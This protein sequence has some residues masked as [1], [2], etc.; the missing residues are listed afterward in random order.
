MAEAGSVLV[1]G[2][3]LVDVIV[4]DGVDGVAGEHPGGSPANVAFGLAR[5]GSQV[6]LL[7]DL[8]D[9]EYGRLVREHLVQAGVVLVSQNR[10][11]GVTSSA[12]AVLASD[13]SA[14][15]EFKLAWDVDVSLAPL[16]PTVHTGSLGAVLGDERVLQ[17]IA[18]R[19]S[20]SVISYDP[21]IR[22]DAMGPRGELLVR[23]ERLVGLSDLVK[24]SDEDLAWLYP[25]VSAQNA[26]Q[27]WAQLGPRAVIV[28]CGADGVRA[29][30]PDA[31]LRVAAFEATV[32]DTVGAGDS[33][34]AALLHSLLG[35]GVR[36]AD[37]LRLG[38]DGWRAALAFAAAAA[39][40]TV[41][42]SG[43]DLPWLAEVEAKLA[44]K[45]G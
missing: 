42:R 35:A 7:T 20:E 6:A 23:V 15:Y 28:T 27:A 40:V 19:R 3:A 12:T 33:F 10:P 30:T 37:D 25:A 43:A 18:A 38:A 41:T 11:G 2:E 8:G 13:G 34:M 9:D 5:L 1:V 31:N 39:A 22:P 45:G 24:V 36:C 4:G 32:L 44:C 16:A 17:L 21:N 26:A 14:R 29:F